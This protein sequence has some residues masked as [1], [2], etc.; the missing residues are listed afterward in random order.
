ME[1]L[2][3]FRSS[4]MKEGQWSA[5][6]VKA[7]SIDQAKEIFWDRVKRTW[8]NNMVDHLAIISIQLR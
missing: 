2:I 1:Y 3:K 8:G 7:D 4:F 6:T 5:F